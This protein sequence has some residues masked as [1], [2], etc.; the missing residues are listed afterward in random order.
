MDRGELQIRDSSATRGH[1]YLV[2]LRE[3]NNN[4]E[5]SIGFED[6]ARNLADYAS[7]KLSSSDSDALCLGK[8]K[9]IKI[10]Q[11]RSITENLL[12]PNSTREERWGLLIQFPKL[13]KYATEDF[14]DFLLSFL[15]LTFPYTGV[16]EEEGLE[17]QSIES[18]FERN[19]K[20]RSICISFHGY[21]CKACNEKLRE[22][23]GD[24]ARNFIHIHHLN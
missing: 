11:Y 19:L 14:V 2:T 23:Y 6:Y 3:L 10:I 17:K 12:E 20:N 18:R 16:A 21:S 4:W 8:A 13:S 7:K 1:G 15:F 22:K 5:A 24:V 9:G